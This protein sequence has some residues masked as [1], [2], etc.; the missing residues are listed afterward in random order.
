MRAFLEV[1]PTLNV[2][3]N[4]RGLLEMVQVERVSI[5][6]DRTR[7]SVY[8]ESPRLMPRQNIE[9]MEEGIRSQLFPQKNVQIR[10]YEKFRLSGRS[11]IHT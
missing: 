3:E 2:T 11:S 6:R 4:L 9:K 5:N 1:F 10:I 8:I 7:I